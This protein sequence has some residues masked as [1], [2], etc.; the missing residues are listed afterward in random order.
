MPEVNR[1]DIS[2]VLMQV[3]RLVETIE[4]KVGELTREVDSIDTYP[5]CDCACDEDIRDLQSDLEALYRRVERL[6]A[7]LPQQPG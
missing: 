1:Y 6:E 7:M 2:N 3:E 4:D 5:V